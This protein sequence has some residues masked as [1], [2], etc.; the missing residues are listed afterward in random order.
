MGE[1]ALKIIVI[2]KLE[3][4]S[5]SF[6]YVNIPSPF[7]GLEYKSLSFRYVNIP[8]PFMGEGLG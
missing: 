1:G 4:K 7:M 5:L 3:Y 2:R 8:S 6:R